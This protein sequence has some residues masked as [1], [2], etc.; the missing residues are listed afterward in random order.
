MIKTVTLETAKA[1]KEAGFPQITD[2][3]WTEMDGSMH[4]TEMRGIIHDDYA[5]PTS[6]EIL[7][8]LASGIR[9]KAHHLY[10]QMGKMTDNLFTVSY[11]SMTDIE[12]DI[13]KDAESLPEALAAMWLYLKKEGL[14]K[15]KK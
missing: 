15:G 13:Q 1:L 3:F 12:M 7:E 8:E 9:I 5:A 11:R 14:L 2:L 4:I 10:L 6:E